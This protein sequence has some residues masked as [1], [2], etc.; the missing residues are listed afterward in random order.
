MF[1]MCHSVCGMCC[2]IYLS[3]YNYL[4]LYVVSHEVRGI[5]LFINLMH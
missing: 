4:T 2:N 1:L 3:L 5:R